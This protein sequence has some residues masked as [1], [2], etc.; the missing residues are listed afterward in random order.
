MAEPI[1]NATFEALARKAAKFG[2]PIRVPAD[3]PKPLITDKPDDEWDQWLQ[4][5][6]WY[7][8]ETIQAEL[9]K[10]TF[11]NQRLLELHEKLISFGGYRTCLPV[12]EDDLENILDRGQLWY[13]E[14]A[15]MMRGAPSQ[16]HRNSAACW[17][18]N[19]SRTILCT[20]YAMSEDGLWRQH[21][22]LVNFRNQCIVETT[23]PRVAYF[24]FPM[25]RDE[26]QAFAD[27]CY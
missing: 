8:K 6:W 4:N 14:G 11:M 15:M 26:A 24:G 16:C 23:E 2:F 9:A 10:S 1:K 12:V 27:D 3:M 19:K 21:S 5:Q 22:W 7:N 18:A 13:G 20:G 17:E 25:T